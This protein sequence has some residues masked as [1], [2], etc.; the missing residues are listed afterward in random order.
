MNISKYLWLSIFCQ[1]SW[2]PPCAAFVVGILCSLLGIGG[3]ELMG[4]LMLQMQILPQVLL[5]HTIPLFLILGQVTSANTS[6]LSIFVTCSSLLLYSL[7]GSF[8]LNRGLWVGGI[9][10]AG[11]FTGRSLALF[12][13]KNLNRPSVTIF[14]LVTVLAIAFCLLIYDI[15]SEEADFGFDLLCE[16]SDDER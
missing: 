2:L 13:A 16:G 14:A 11:G 8:P 9:G 5:L 1:V 6:V 4:P 3:G 15:T 7:R 12:L 10:L